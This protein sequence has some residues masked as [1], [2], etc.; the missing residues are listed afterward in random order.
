MSSKD[1]SSSAC[2]LIDGVSDLTCGS[3]RK[4]EI[5]AEHNHNKVWDS[6][7]DKVRTKRCEYV[8]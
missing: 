7:V 5:R 3:N 2:P 8:R 1:R 6:D 4:Q